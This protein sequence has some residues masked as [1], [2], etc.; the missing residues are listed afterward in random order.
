MFNIG[1][2]ILGTCAWLF[3]GFAIST[4]KAVISHRNTLASFCFCVISLVLQFFEVNR[5]VLLDD[6]AAIEDTIGAVLVASVAM[7]VITIILNLIAV[8][9]AKK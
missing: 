2:F 6:Y 5:R 9:K 3:A 7:V 1:S 8:V 4:S